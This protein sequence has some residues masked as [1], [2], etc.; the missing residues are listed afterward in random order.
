MPGSC[1]IEDCGKP[2]VSRKLCSKH[3]MRW[4]KFGDPL[5]PVRSY[6][7]RPAHCQADEDPPCPGTVVSRGLCSKHYTRFRKYGDASVVMTQGNME[8]DPKVRFRSKYRVDP[9]TGCWMWTAAANGHGWATISINGKATMAHRYSYEAFRGPIPEGYSVKRVCGQGRCVNPDHLELVS[10]DPVDR[11]WANVDKREDGCW[12]WQSSGFVYRVAGKPNSPRRYAWNLLRGETKDFLYGLCGNKKC[13]NPDHS[14]VA[15][16]RF[17]AK[18]DKAVD[19]CWYW[20]G[21]KL[22][23]GYPHLTYNGVSVYAH[24]LTYEWAGGV[25]EEG[26][27]LAH[28][29]EHLSCVNPDHLEQITYQEM[30]DRREEKKHTVELSDAQQGVM[31]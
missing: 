22:A 26:S 28:K 11:F 8:V 12:D 10:N 3:Y 20:T 21:S 14:G 29:C 18:V 25:L 17:W 15:K 2:V 7:K 1:S 13:V 23:S 16:D 9:D 30:V 5:K 27:V 4:R 24:R 31:V 19:G 6:Q